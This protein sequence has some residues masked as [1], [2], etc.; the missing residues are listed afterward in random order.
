MKKVIT[1][2]SSLIIFA[3]T[4]TALLAQSAYS[5]HGEKLSDSSEIKSIIQSVLRNAKRNAAAYYNDYQFNIESI[6]E[7]E[8]ENKTKTTL[9]EEGS[10][11]PITTIGF[12]AFSLPPPCAVIASSPIARYV[13]RVSFIV[14]QSG[15]GLR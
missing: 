5:Q 13:L 4:I 11:D 14:N 9:F 2:L 1:K 3:V 12:T 7:V 10:A 6:I 8:G 15:D